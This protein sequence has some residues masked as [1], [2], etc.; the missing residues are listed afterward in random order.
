MWP[1]PYGS[2][3]GSRKYL[4]ASLNQSLTRLGL[5]YVDI[6]YSH[7]FDVDT[8][9]EETMGALVS[10]VH[11]GKALYVGVSSYSPKKTAEAA[12]IL[13]RANVPASF[14]NRRTICSIAGSNMVSSTPSPK[15]GSVASRSARWRK[16]S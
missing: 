2:G 6:F 1:G 13:R 12:A 5:D 4:L 15:R 9:L 11:Q 7:R 3:G 16:G 14:I 10:A 8:P